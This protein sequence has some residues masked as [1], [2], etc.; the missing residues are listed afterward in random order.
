VKEKPVKYKASEP[1]SLELNDAAT[2]PGIGLVIPLRAAK[3][4]LSALLEFVS[5]GQQVTITSGGVPKVVLTPATPDAGRKR[6]T[7]MG[8]FLSSQ[9]VHTAAPAEEVVRDDRDSRGW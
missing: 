6:F 8:D 1:A 7:G 5:A 2:M 4:K 3:A 9:R